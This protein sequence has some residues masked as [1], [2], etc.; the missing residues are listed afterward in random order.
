[1]LAALGAAFGNP[2][3]AVEYLFS[4]I[5]PDLMTA[6]PA[7]TTPAP[8]PAPTPAPAPAPMQAAVPAPAAPMFSAASIMQ[9][10]QPAAPPPSAMQQ[11][12]ADP[13][14]LQLIGMVCH[15][16]APPHPLSFYL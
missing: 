10:L 6:V 11:M 12:L 14:M 3:R 9:A 7:A 5:P 8:A 16:L 4:G 15:N 13:Q 1:M 2:E